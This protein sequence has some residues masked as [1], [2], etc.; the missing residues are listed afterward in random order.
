MGGRWTSVI[1]V[2]L[3]AA[4]SCVDAGPDDSETTRATVEPE[5]SRA[6]ADVPTSAIRVPVGSSIQEAVDAAEEGS[7]F[8]LESG[9]HRLQQIEPK[10]GDTF[11]GEEGAVLSGAQVLDAFRQEGDLWVH[12]GVSVAGEERGQSACLPE[13]PACSL[14][15]DLFVDDELIR[16]VLSVEEVDE[17]SWFLDPASGELW[18]GRDPAGRTV[19]I[20]VLPLAFGGEA[21]RVTLEGLVVEKYASPAQRGAVATGTGWTITNTEVRFNHGQGVRL[22]TGL[23][24]SDSYLHHNG[25][26]GIAGGG[27]GAQII[28]N[29]ISHNGTAGFSALWAAGGT[30]FLHVNDLVVEGNFVHSNRGPGL[31]TD[32]GG[33]GTTYENNRVVGNEHAGIKHEISGTANITGNHVEGNGFENSVDYRGAGILVRESGPASISGNK[34]LG[35]KDA[36]VLLH[37]DDRT[38]DTGNRLTG[39]VVTGNDIAFDGGRLGYIGDVSEGDLGTDIVFEGNRYYGEESA[40]VFVVKGRALDF[41]AWKEMAHDNGSVVEARD[42]FP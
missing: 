9:V 34:V 19:E 20:S 42:S 1:L 8:L 23:T 11:L 12:D 35:N 7:V 27:V 15:E 4:S 32:G 2:G 25:Q 13:Y 28:G 10:N 6:E 16:R 26:F 29:E 3:L 18:L 40:T 30:K 17:D 38:N 24:V 14:P 37:D 36:I 33:N 39:I 22:G 31:W 41:A 5:W 21:N